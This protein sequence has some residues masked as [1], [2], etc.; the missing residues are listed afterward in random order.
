MKIL[1]FGHV[2]HTGFGVV[3]ENLAT[4]FLAAGHDPRILAV[5]HRGEP[6]LGPLAGRVWPALIEGDSHGGNISQDAIAGTLWQRYGHPEWKPDIVLVIADMSGLAAHVGRKGVTGPWLE[7]PVYHYCPIEG[8]NLPANWGRVWNLFKP[9]AM[10]KFGAD[11]IGAHIGRPVPMIY[12]GVDTAT[13]RPPAFNDPLRW[14][15]TR[16]LTKESCRTP[17]G[18]KQDRKYILRTDRLVERKFYHVFIETMVQVMRARDDVDAII[19]CRPVDPP[20]DLSAEIER[21]PE[22]LRPR[23]ILSGLHDTFRGLPTEGLV[24]LYNAADLLFSPTGGEGFGLTLAESLACETPV[25][26]TAWAAEKEVVAKGGVLVPP[27]T[28]NRGEVV[29]YHS[30]YGM[31][32]A[33]PDGPAFV[34]PILDLLAHPSRRKALGKEGRAHVVK[35]FSWDTAAAA[36]LT[37]FEESYGAA[38]D[39]LAG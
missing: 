20:L 6:I 18:L 12:H 9:V 27:R 22:D 39:R 37:L 2:S 24:T 10:A 31:D 25:V 29:R 14:E 1:I 13:F 16:F 35:S 38:V 15:G 21:L 30:Q 3:T 11:V 33:I 8:D 26:T 7:T 28:D 32:W 19:H 34:E 17:F 5:N 23:F 4:R 36:F